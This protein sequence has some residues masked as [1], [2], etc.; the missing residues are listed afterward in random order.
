MLNYAWNDFQ[1]NLTLGKITE[2]ENFHCDKHTS[3]QS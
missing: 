3:D 2:E 1:K